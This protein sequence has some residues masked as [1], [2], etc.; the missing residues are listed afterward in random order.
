MA[1][2]YGNGLVNRVVG[3]GPGVPDSISISAKI[4]S[5]ATPSLVSGPDVK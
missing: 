5:F 2:I 4:L 1:F 3:L